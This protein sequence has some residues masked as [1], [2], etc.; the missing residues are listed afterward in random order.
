MTQFAENKYQFNLARPA[1]RRI[2]LQACLITGAFLLC[3]LLGLGGGFLLLPTYAHEFT[4]Y[5]KWQDALVGSCWCVALVSLGGCILMLRFLYALRC[6]Y[7]QGMITLE[8][9]NKLAGRDLSPKNFASIFW[10]VA[11]TFSCFVVVQLGLIPAILLGWTVHFPSPVL[12]FFSTILALLVSIGG[13]VVSLPFGAFFIIGLVGGISF[14]RKMGALQ[15]YVLNN[16]TTLRIDGFV[17]AVIHPDKPE[18]LFDL[19]L[20]HPSDQRQL[21][22][23]LRERWV[24]AERPWNPSFGDEIEAALRK[25]E[26]QVVST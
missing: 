26:R 23:L 22:T 10:L 12:A 2:G 9:R 4:W 11:T 24:E 17:L 8:D 14:C 16:Q 18:S 7:K 5:L 13:L 3:V 19:H 20:L 1:Y 25:A 15:D 21:L 6:G